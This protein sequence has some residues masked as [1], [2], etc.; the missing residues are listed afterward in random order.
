M[1]MPAASDASSCVDF[2]GTWPTPKYAESSPVPVLDIPP[3]SA[4]P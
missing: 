2:D 1:T 3:V 4:A